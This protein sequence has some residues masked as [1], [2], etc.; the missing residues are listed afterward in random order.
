MKKIK[1][2]GP[3]YK[4]IKK[5]YELNKNNIESSVLLILNKLLNC[6]DDRDPIS[7]NIFW[8]ENENIRSIVYPLDQLDKLVFYND[9]NNKIKCLEK[10]S[11]IYLKTYNIFNHPVSMEPIPK[12]LF[13]SIQT[14]E[15]NINNSI[16]DY[17]LNVFQLFTMK[18]IFI[19][20][21]LFINLNNNNLLKFN[22]EIKD[23]WN[24]NL[25]PNQKNI[26]SKEPLFLKNNSELSKFND[27]D[28]IRYFLKNIKIAL[29]CTKEEI[30]LLINY[31][32]I[33]ALGIVIPEIKNDYSD[34]IFSFT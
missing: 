6:D 22:S 27:E 15:I 10:E 14:I 21:R 9:K 19:D 30:S 31:I 2:N 32:I 18:S 4:I 16:E 34:V 28:I 7:M 29:E 3:I 13:D 20:Y 23:I 12:E 24:Q 8:K 11:I 1:E 26:I 33:G 25:T 17:A 5:E